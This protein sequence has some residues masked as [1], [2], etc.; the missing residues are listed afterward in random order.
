MD[1]PRHGEGDRS[2]QPNG[3]GESDVR[4]DSTKAI[5]DAESVGGLVL[6]ALIAIAYAIYLLITVGVDTAMDGFSWFWDWPP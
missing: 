5:E 1:P 2:A 6:P 3:G 4:S